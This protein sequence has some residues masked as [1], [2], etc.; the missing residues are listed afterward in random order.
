VRVWGKGV[1][2]LLLLPLS[3]FSVTLFLAG[4]DNRA[5]ST[6][7]HPRPAPRS[8]QN[9]RAETISRSGF[10]RQHAAPSQPENGCDH[11]AGRQPPLQRC[12]KDTAIAYFVWPDFLRTTVSTC[13]AAAAWSPALGSERLSSRYPADS[14]S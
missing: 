1:P 4:S 5:G 14:L 8:T 2:L 7:K 9:S 12:G 3:T 6:G 10:G 11:A 13:F